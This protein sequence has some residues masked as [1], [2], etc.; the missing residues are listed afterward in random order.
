MKQSKLSAERMQFLIKQAHK[1]L[2][3]IE[4]GIDKIQASEQKKA[5]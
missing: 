4:S 3:V 1:C 5:A 2:D